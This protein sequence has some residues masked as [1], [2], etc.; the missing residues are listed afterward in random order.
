[1]TGQSLVTV[2]TPVY[3]G[4]A[5]IGQC[6]ESVLAQTY[7]DWEYVIVNNCSTDRSLSVAQRYAERDPRIR[8][9]TNE[10]FVNVITNHNITF[11]LLSPESK[12]CKVVHADDWLSSSGPSPTSTATGGSSSTCRRFRRCW[13]GCSAR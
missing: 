9:V 5:F 2:L 3:N 1:M 4:E 11:R 13:P 8:V 12:Y 7:E 10:R 6:I